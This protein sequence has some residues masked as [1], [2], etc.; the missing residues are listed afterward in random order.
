M[1]KAKALI[2]ERAGE[3]VY[4]KDPDLTHDLCRLWK[5]YCH[6]C[7]QFLYFS[8]SKDTDKRRSY[9]GHYDYEDKCC[10]ERSLV[11]SK[12]NQPASFTESH[13]QD[14][15][16][17]E[18]FV[19][20]VFYGIDPEYFQRLNR[21]GDEEE[22]R[23]VIDVIE[24]FKIS[25]PHD[26]KSWIEH[27]CQTIGF[28]DW[29]NP[30][31]EVSYL[32]DWLR[33]L[34]RRNDILKNLAQYF[35]SECIDKQ[36]DTNSI[37]ARFGA[38]Q[39]IESEPELVWLL[40]LNKIL[41]RLANVISKEGYFRGRSNF[42]G[43]K[44][45]INFK[46]PAN[47]KKTPFKGKLRYALTAKQ[48][49]ILVR[50]NESRRFNELVF[51]SDEYPNFFCYRRHDL[52][53]SIRP[54]FIKDDALLLYIDEDGDLAV[55]GFL[56]EVFAKSVIDGISK[57]LFNG[58]GYSMLVFFGKGYISRDIAEK[59]A[60]LALKFKFGDLS[61]PEAFEKFRSLSGIKT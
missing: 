50:Q 23:K 58:S 17:A 51:F 5:I 10:P 55:Q 13:E 34:D 41:A 32:M 29:N 48:M 47:A 36:V 59:A 40:A 61:P 8:K 57:T 53:E 52:S 43:E 33:V 22:I 12:R 30:K 18:L 42:L 56:D 6:E 54:G 60:Q 45:F 38:S 9:F 21:Q 44:K 49:S 2:G 39:K 11:V 4:A 35:I 28:L 24:W 27:Y 15:E 7:K 1:Y 3:V 37:Q 19:D 26:C 20:K 25:F 31:K 46:I 16:T 14:L